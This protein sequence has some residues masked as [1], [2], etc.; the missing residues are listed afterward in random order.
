MTQ[1]ER[2]TTRPV[3]ALTVGAPFATATAAGRRGWL[4]AG[5]ALFACAWG[6]NQFTPLLD[7]YRST[8][9]WSETVVDVLLAAYVFG[10]TPALL[11]GGHVSRRWGP[12]RSV[13]A[14]IVAS[15]IGSG[16]L[17]TGALAGVALGRLMSGVGV[18]LA[19]A[20]GTGWATDLSVAGGA[21]PA[22]GARRSALSL[23]AG[24]AL[25]AGAAG[26][27][28][29]WGPW[30][31]SLPYA[32]HAV[33]AVIALAAALAPTSG[34][35]PATAESPAPERAL[36][37]PPATV[38]TAT[39]PTAGGAP[40]ATPPWEDP[41]HPFVR[42]RRLRRIVL[43]VAPW[44][45]GSAAVA[46]AILPQAMAPHVGHYALVFATAL[47]VIT[48]GAG[49]L[50][51]PL[52]R[53]LDHPVTPHALRLAMGLVVAG[54]LT[55]VAAVAAA[56]PEVALAAA[57]ILGAGYGVTLLAGLLEIQRIAAPD[58]VAR[59]T[60]GFYA[61]T[62]VGFLLPAVLAALVH[63][64]PLPVELAVLAGLAALSAAAVSAHRPA[65]I[66]G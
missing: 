53:R 8:E 64:V 45:F 58:E 44:V 12:R 25:G 42:R 5:A 29:Q 43:P 49:I 2:S 39:V 30:P 46:Y 28:A 50:A 38:P 32:A 34:R 66:G 65:P 55:A 33:V 4:A 61:M 52:A 19:M 15:L 13:A 31:R 20:V 6:G 27:L 14:A 62:Y 40:S 54:L 16:L 7:L 41:L 22:A 51:Q 59:L 9:G 11:L 3:A 57:V 23:T 37:E 60:G 48:L 36:P 56:S 63:W 47:T 24:F 35:R 17:A 21:S 10:L 18:G 26:I 1:V